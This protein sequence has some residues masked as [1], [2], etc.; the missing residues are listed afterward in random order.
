MDKKK[1]DGFYFTPHGDEDDGLKFSFFVLS[2]EQ[3]GKPIG[4]NNMGDM[5]HIVMFKKGDDGLPVYDETFDA[6]LIDPE[7]YV[8]NLVGTELYGC[9]LRK[10]D[11]SHKWLEDYLT[12]VMGSVIIKKLNFMK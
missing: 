4:G 11:K 7:I 5:Y 6:I 12:R 9:V 10:T 1:Y 8:E 3:K 2:D